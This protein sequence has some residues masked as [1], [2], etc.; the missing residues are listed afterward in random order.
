MHLVPPLALVLM[1][2]KIQ[3][4]MGPSTIVLSISIHAT[5]IALEILAL[6]LYFKGDT[7]R[8]AH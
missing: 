3:E 1:Y 2:G 6:V 8:E 7:A 4:V 5:F